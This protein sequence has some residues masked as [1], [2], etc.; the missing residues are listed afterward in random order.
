MA[1]TWKAEDHYQE[2]IP[3]YLPL[4]FQELSSVHQAPVVTMLFA[5]LSC[6][7]QP[8]FCFFLLL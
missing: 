2:L 6:C 7:L 1:H 4:G 3:T 5:E 8:T